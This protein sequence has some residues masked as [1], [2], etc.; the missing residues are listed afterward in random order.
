MIVNDCKLVELYGILVGDGY[1]HKNNWSIIIV[2]SS[3]EKDYLNNRVVPFFVDLFGKKPKITPRRDK[4]AYYIQV[5]SKEIVEFLIQTFGM[6]RGEKSKYRISEKVIENKRLIPHFLRGL[7]DT[8]GCIKFSKQG[9]N[10]NYYPRIQFYFKNGPLVGD[11]KIL[12]SKMG[13]SY[14]AYEDKRFGGL[15]VIQVS[16]YKNL[17][18]WIKL[19]G[20]S[21]PVHVTKIL[22]WKKYGFVTPKTTLEE[23]VK[24]L[25]YKHMSLLDSKEP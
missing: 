17:E 15:Y 20:S 9:K 23:R 8:D 4:K 25:D 11:L 12:L 19:I 18:K 13:F 14:S 6:T 7:F 24:D 2:C 3:E 21:N 5:N 16:G 1:L 22:Q 10:I